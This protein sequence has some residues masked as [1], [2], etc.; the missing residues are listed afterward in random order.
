MGQ[1]GFALREGV[2]QLAAGV[3]AAEENV[4]YGIGA[5]TAREPCFQNRRGRLDPRHGDGVAGFENH[6][7]VGVGLGHRGDDVVLVVRQREVGQVHAFAGPA[8]GE[9]DGHVRALGGL[10]SL[11]RVGAGVVLHRGVR[12]ACLNGLQ[13]RGWEP[14]LFHPVRGAF[15]RGLDGIAADGI[16]LRR[17]AAGDHTHV[18]VRAD[19]G[20]GAQL[21]RAERKSIL[22]VL[23][24]NDTGLFNL[25]R[26]LHAREGIDDEALAGIVDDAGGEHGAQNALH[27]LIEFGLRNAAGFNS[28]L[29]T[30][31]V[32][33]AAGLFVVEAGGRCL[34]DRVSA[35]P[36]REH[37]AGEIPVLL[38]HVG[39]QPFVLAGKVAIHAIV[40][41]HHGGGLAF[42]HADFK[43]EQIAFARGALADVNVHRVAAALLVVEGVVLDVADDVGR[44]RA[45]D[46][47]RYKRAGEHRVFA[48]VLKG[49]A[50]AR[51]AGEVDAT[52][53]RHVEALRAQLTANQRTVFVGC[54]HIPTAGRSHVGRQRGGVAA[55]DAAGA[56][57]V[58]GVAHVDAGNAEARHANGVAH[59]AIRRR[60]L[61]CD[62]IVGGHA[63]TMQ[64]RDLF[65]ERHLFEHQRGALVGGEARVH[66]RT[67]GGF[68]G[69]V[70]GK[71][72]SGGGECACQCDKRGGAAQVE[73]RVHHDYLSTKTFVQNRRYSSR[74]VQRLAWSSLNR[75]T[76]V[77]HAVR[78]AIDSRGFCRASRFV[79]TDGRPAPTRRRGFR[80]PEFQDKREWRRLRQWPGDRRPW[81][82]RS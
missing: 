6:D 66:P 78:W 64:Q 72:R 23:E 71:R 42:K 54:I 44:L 61:R 63:H 25:A 75:T 3:H 68:G 45:L 2:D 82:P 9:D 1:V 69:V 26:R 19:D 62:R 4:G 28:V 31:L 38:Q 32:E 7:G 76:S 80:L 70:L 17:T 43:G 16:D 8:I 79:R 36:V 21:G 74:P 59:A 27:M 18:G 47:V 33:E 35:A 30:L 73:W 48:Q 46:E 37:E 52:A 5:V 57:T 55:V 40:A 34:L 65:V 60:I 50:V 51:V 11:G 56:H 53:E 10:S 41:A 22:F 15:A 58:G 14:D 77:E 81:P 39:E 24:Q 67:G 13:R 12:S 29:V 49:A 20:D